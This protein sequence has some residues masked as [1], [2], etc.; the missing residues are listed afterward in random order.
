VPLWV[1]PFSVRTSQPSADGTARHV[2][3]L[4]ATLGRHG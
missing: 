4:K 1:F 2:A 3:C